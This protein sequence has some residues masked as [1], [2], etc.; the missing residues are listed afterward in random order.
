MTGRQTEKIV[1][2]C[3]ETSDAK[4]GIRVFG[5][6]EE[7]KQAEFFLGTDK[8]AEIDSPAGRKS[9]VDHKKREPSVLFRHKAPKK[10]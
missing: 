8:S 2:P 6:H 1:R 4:I 5:H 3:F 10:P 9:G 7:W